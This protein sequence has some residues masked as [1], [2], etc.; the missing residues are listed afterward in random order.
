MVTDPDWGYWF[1]ERLRDGWLWPRNLVRDG[2][3]R[4]RR[5]GQVC[6]TGAGGLWSL[7]AE[8]KAGDGRRL[9]NKKGKRLIHGGHL[10]CVG[11]FDLLGG[12]ELAQFFTRLFTFTTPLS[13]EE[14]AVMASILGETGLRYDE[15]RIAE[16]G[17][18]E[19]VF[20]INGQLAFTSWYTINL[21]RPSP[22]FPA[23][24]TRANR[25]LLVHELV[26]VYQYENVGSRYMTEAIYELVRTKRDCYQYGGGPGLV[27]AA[28][29]AKAYRH[30]NREQ[31]AQI[32]QDFYSKRERGEAVE[33]YYPYVAQC[34]KGEL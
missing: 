34:R 29:S 31:Q 9:L 27:E 24:H 19:N 22:D 20:K 25:A 18:W 4:L 15:V 1:R 2:R 14:R 16:G 33:A 5:L 21:P 11:V 13:A 10:L 26:H 17:L 28:Q 6:R 32:V 23:A 12:P 30:F 7:P 3:Q 8:M